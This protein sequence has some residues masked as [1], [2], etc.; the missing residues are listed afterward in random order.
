MQYI[1]STIKQSTIRWGM[2]LYIP[3]NHIEH[4]SRCIWL[5]KHLNK[6]KRLKTIRSILSDHNGI[7]L[8]INNRKIA[9]NLLLQT[10]CL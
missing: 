1:G 8:E 5:H 7:R 2:P 3:L 4:S 6:F 9:G 10:E